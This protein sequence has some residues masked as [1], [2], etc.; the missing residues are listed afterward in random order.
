MGP[1]LTH[2]TDFSPWQHDAEIGEYSATDIIASIESAATAAIDSIRAAG[3]LSS[4][5][6]GRAGW[7][8]IASA[9][10][11]DLTLGSVQASA[12]NASHGIADTFA[13]S[14]D[15][16]RPIAMHP[17]VDG[18]TWSANLKTDSPLTVADGASAE[19]DGRTPQSVTFA[20]TTGTLKIDHS[21]A[22]AGE[23][24]GLT[25][26][27]TL[28]LADLSYSANTTATFSGNANSGTLTITNGASSAHIDLVG[29]FLKS[30]WTLSSDGHGGT[31]VVDPP[32]TGAYPNA[33][34][35][36]VPAGTVLK[37]SGS[38]VLSTPGEVVNGLDISGGVDIQA[39]NVTLENC[40]IHVTDA[41][42]QWVVSVL[43]GLT[44]VTIQ[45]CEIIGPGLSA[46]NQDAGI[47]IIGDSQVTINA[48]NIHEVGHGID[49]SGGPVVVEN[50]YIHDLN[51][52]S[53]SHYDGIYF[54][55]GSSP[56]FSLQIQNNTIIN[57]NDQTSAVFLENYFGSI[58]NV[59]VNNNLLVGGGYTLYLVSNTQSNGGGG[60]GGAV[61]NVSYTNNDIGSGYWGPNDFAGPY[62][63]VFTGNVND[64]AA[65]A[66]AL[67]VSPVVAAASA[68]AGTYSTGNTVI[69]TLYTS[70]AVEVSGSPTLT[71]SNGATATYTGSPSSDSLTFSYT[72]ANGQNTSALSVTAINGTIT[73][74][75]GHKLST[76]NLSANFAGV[77]ID[78]PDASLPLR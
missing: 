41:N 44:G 15:G 74:Y 27:D 55:G 28:D 78:G 8:G 26:A 52:A 20:G 51:A 57:Q 58:N 63:P 16:A 68:T 70:E 33:T 54:G 42:A 56:N 17:P 37:P 22:F 30:G 24:S 71:L 23:I 48:V 18:G 49:V 13:E 35:T 25:G 47:Y 11:G 10:D 76:S 61:S 75:D 12:G 9:S 45:N 40:I 39:S 4:S 60:E 2:R 43:G 73:D 53:S 32:L 1:D 6:E 19:I 59:S 38:L 36:G 29:D 65:L 3:S 31:L 7:H 62:V 77:S 66:A 67:P 69:L 64:G 46:N 50:S 21:Q 72:V 5:Q 34:N 14:S